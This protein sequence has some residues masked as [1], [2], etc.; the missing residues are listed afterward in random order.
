MTAARYPITRHVLFLGLGRD[1]SDDTKVDHRMEQL[2][3]TGPGDWT[4]TGRP[5]RF[6]GT[7]KAA[8]LRSHMSPGCVYAVEEKEEGSFIFGRDAAVLVGRW[9][10]DGERA[11]INAASRAAE[12]AA[13]YARKEA[14]RD[15]ADATMGAA[16]IAQLAQQYVRLVSSRDRVAFELTVLNA[17]RRKH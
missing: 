14:K 9:P 16:T 8:K 3:G 2:A 12:A 11:A 15:V 6:G 4:R 7:G 1:P 5:L 10:D 17:L 13:A